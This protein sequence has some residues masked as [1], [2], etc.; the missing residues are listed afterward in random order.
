MRDRQYRNV[1][2][3]SLGG[4][5]GAVSNVLIVGAGPA[6]LSSAIALRRAG[7]AVDLVERSPTRDVPGSELMVG[8]S[9]LR[10]LDVL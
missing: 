3:P 7:I 8:G 5:M 1:A 9:F 6:G 2:D 10:S 4:A